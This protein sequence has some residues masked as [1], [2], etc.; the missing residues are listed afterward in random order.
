VDRIEATTA[1][2]ALGSNLGDRRSHLDYAVSRL[3][4]L[5]DDLKVSGYYNTA[6]VGV[7]GDQPDFLNAAAVGKTTMTARELL[8]RLLTVELDRGRQRPHPA[9]ARTLDLDLVLFGEEI[10]NDPPGL[11]VPHPRFRDRAFVLDPLAEIAADLRDPVTEKTVGELRRR[12]VG[13][14]DQR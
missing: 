3:R 5:L 4:A 12:I 6:P 8:S 13:N 9:A 10:I 7:A 14:A 2:I 11:I 1:A